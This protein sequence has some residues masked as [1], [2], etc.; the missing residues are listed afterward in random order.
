MSDHTP[1]HILFEQVTQLIR[2]GVQSARIEIIPILRQFHKHM[3]KETRIDF[4]VAYAY[5]LEVVEFEN[6]INRLEDIILQ[7]IIEKLFE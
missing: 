5:P 2:L 3:L 1:D 7:R 4:G 6:T